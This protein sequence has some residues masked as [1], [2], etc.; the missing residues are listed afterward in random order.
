M[1]ASQQRPLVTGKY[2]TGEF[3]PNGKPRS[4]SRAERK[5][6]RRADAEA[7]AVIRYTPRQRKLTLARRPGNAARELERLP[8]GGSR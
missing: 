1:I 5:A 4:A 6:A 7:R 8:S 2:A 3:H